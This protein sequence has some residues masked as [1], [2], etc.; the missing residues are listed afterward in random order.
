[1]VESYQ[2]LPYNENLREAGREEEKNWWRRSVIKEAGR[3]WMN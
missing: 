3:S 1:M 2:R